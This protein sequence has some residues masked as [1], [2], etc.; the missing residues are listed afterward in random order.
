[1]SQVGVTCSRVAIDKTKAK[2]ELALVPGSVALTGGQIYTTITPP[3]HHHH[4]TI[5]S[6]TDHITGPTAPEPCISSHE[7]ES[8]RGVVCTIKRNRVGCVA[9][10]Q[11]LRENSNRDEPGATIVLKHHRWR[12]RFHIA[13]ERMVV[14]SIKQSLARMTRPEAICIGSRRGCLAREQGLSLPGGQSL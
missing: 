9:C 8:E 7:L 10:C 11:K 4:T 5:T 1:M 13:S 6:L 12:A 2:E 14:E 3:S